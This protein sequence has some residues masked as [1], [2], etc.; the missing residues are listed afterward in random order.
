MLRW[1]RPVTL[2]NARV[3]TP[4]GLAAS[5]RFDARVLGVD[6]PPGA[7]DTVV[8]VEGAF[9]LPGLVNAHDHLELNHYGPLKPRERYDNATEWIEDLRPVIRDDPTIRA[10]AAHPLAARLFIGGLKNLLAG[11]TTVAHHNPRYRTIDRHVPVR[12]VERYGWAHSFAMADRP[13]GANG[14][15]GGAVV[16]RCLATAA[17]VPFIVHAAEGIDERAR[18][19]IARLEH[20]GCLRP[21]TVLVHGVAIGEEEWRAMVR[22]GASLVWCPA[23]NRFLFG[24]TAPVA[25][26]MDAMPEAPSRICLGTDSRLTGALDLLDELRVARE[27]EGIPPDTLLHMVTATSA[28]ILR[29]RHAGRIAVGAPADIVVVPAAAA[30]PGAALLAARRADVLLVAIN[31]RPLVGA[32]SMAPAFAA[33]G[34]PAVG[35]SVDGTA[36]LLAQPF[37]RLLARCPIVEPGVQVS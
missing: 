19:E 22:T 33:R 15:P 37:G 34:T 4:D 25:K 9:V 21:N 2:V 8:D 7:E 14:E 12:V 13:V 26:L 36:R 1:R 28:R 35:V 5:L 30:T 3:V 27:L 11:V 29:L 23:S 32:T 10:R 6:A 24:R 20:F 16:S 31:G 18:Q 17:D